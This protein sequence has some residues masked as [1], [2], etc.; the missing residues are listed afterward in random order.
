MNVTISKAVGGR[1]RTGGATSPLGMSV[2]GSYFYDVANDASDVRKIQDLL[3]RL[4]VSRVPIPVTGRCDPET[5]DGIM[6]FQKLFPGLPAPDG[7]V[8]PGG[9]TLARMNAVASPLEL[10]APKLISP[11]YGA[12]QLQYTGTRPPEPYRVLLNVCTQSPLPLVADNALG[13]EGEY[14][15]EVTTRPSTG[16]LDAHNLPEFLGLV[17]KR[18]LWADKTAFVRLIVVRDTLVVSVSN[19]QQFKPPVKPWAKSVTPTE[20]GAGDDG[21]K[22]KYIG[23]GEAPFI[24]RYFYSKKIG[25]KCYWKY[26]SELVTEQQY[27]GFD[28]ITFVGSVYLKDATTANNPYAS[29]ANMAS[30]LGATALVWKS[31][32]LIEAERKEAAKAEAEKKKEA[33]MTEAQKKDAAQKKKKFAEENQIQDGEGKGA[34]VKKYFAQLS[35]NTGTYLLWK[36]SHITLVINKRVHEFGHSKGGYSVTDVSNWVGDTVDYHLYSLPAD[37]QF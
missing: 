34:A 26:A 37:K 27:R 32:E 14:C 4:A 17:E 25:G 5:V 30:A 7:K 28:C 2:P 18:D 36:G 9:K 33:A 15:M 16:L 6:T 22:L 3:N 20:L 31:P 24:G 21:P 10:K 35:G 29:S 23:S 11:D 19:A 12:Y 13:Q 8:D 1:L